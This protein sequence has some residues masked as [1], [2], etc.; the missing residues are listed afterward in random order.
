VV[1]STGA[2]IPLQPFVC[3]QQAMGSLSG[4]GRQYEPIHLT[5]SMV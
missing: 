1:A 2:R 5:N 3:I 4:C